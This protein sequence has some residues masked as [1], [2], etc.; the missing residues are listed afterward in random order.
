[1]LTVD[2][3]RALA[4]RVSQSLDE[5]GH[6]GEAVRAELEHLDRSETFSTQARDAFQDVLARAGIATLHPIGLPPDSEPFW[7]RAGQPLADYR[8][9][10]ELPA[11]ADVVII[12]A[13]LTGA[14]TAYHLGP[15]AASGSLV[16]VL[17]Q[18]DPACEASGR[19][20]G[21][22]ELIPEN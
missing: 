15:H 1:M 8:S 16:V 11:S 9:R 19:N 22:F 2:Q 14:A 10:A 3:V 13:G 12:G 17:E 21:N 4:E 5:H 18:G 6:A 7:L 20:G